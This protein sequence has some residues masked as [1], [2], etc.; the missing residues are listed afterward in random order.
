MPPLSPSKPLII[1][2]KSNHSITGTIP[3]VTKF[4]WGI[5]L[6]STEGVYSVNAGV[7]FMHNYNLL[8]QTLQKRLTP[9][10]PK[11]LHQT[12]MLRKQ[13]TQ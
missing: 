8:Q 3:I 13:K 7:V 1:L 2:S 9:L 4:P 5:E 6:M 12:L 11:S 10:L